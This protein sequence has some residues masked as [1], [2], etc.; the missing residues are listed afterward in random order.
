[1][2]VQRAKQCPHGR[3]PLNWWSRGAVA[4]A[5]VEAT[6]DGQHGVFPVD[7]N[8]VATHAVQCRYW[9]TGNVG[10]VSSACVLTRVLAA[11]C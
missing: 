3:S 2:P 11:Y 1:M 7:S 6:A 10:M 4:A 9:L 5:S 8:G